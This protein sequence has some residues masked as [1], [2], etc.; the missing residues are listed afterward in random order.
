MEGLGYSLL[1]AVITLAALYFVV[2]AAVRGA[3]EESKGEIARA[4]KDG[5]EEYER[6]KQEGGLEEA[7]EEAEFEEE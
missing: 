6:E 4:V 1:S 3:I 7:E 2:K 5:I